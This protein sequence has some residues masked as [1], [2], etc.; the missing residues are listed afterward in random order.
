MGLSSGRVQTPAL[1]LITSRENEIKDFENLNDAE[2]IEYSIS[3]TLNID[4]NQ[5]IINNVETKKKAA[6]SKEEVTEETENTED[7]ESNKD[8]DEKEFSSLKYKSKEE[9]LK[10]LDS[11]KGFENALLLKIESKTIEKA[12]PKPFK[13]SN[14]LKEAVK[15]VGISIKEAQDIAQRLFEKGLITYIRTD[16]E[17]LSLE[18]LKLHKDFYQTKIKEYQYRI[19]KAGSLSQANAHE[20]IRITT[21]MAFDEINAFCDK[22]KLGETEQKIYKLIFKNT[23][24]S[25]AKNA[26]FSQTI[27]HFMIGN[28]AFKTTIN[29]LKELGFLGIFDTKIET[30][31]NEFLENLNENS[32]YK[33]DSLFLRDIKKPSP[34]RIEES[35][36]ISIL[37]RKGIGRPSTYSSYIPLLLKKDYIKILDKKRI[38]FPTQ[39]GLDVINFFNNDVNKWILDLNFTKEMENKLDLIEKDKYTYGEFIKELLSKI[40]GIEISNIGEK[41]KNSIIKNE[42]KKIIAPS[43]KQIDFIKSIESILEIKAPKD[44]F[45]NVYETKKFIE[46]NLETFNGKKRKG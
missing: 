14:F 10:E 17:A 41:T 4:S 5:I 18:Y 8:K 23:I 9:A 26:V 16:S 43:Q 40:K 36:F 35:N 32:L 33:I 24:C 27:L 46:N 28:K 39:T 34:K 12:P 3:A 44:A 31:K 1:F 6:E 45:L 25:Q 22:E 19:Y 7:T 37:E 38:I 20:A 30:L 2:K 15:M 42:N 11:I 29:T 21:P 13:T